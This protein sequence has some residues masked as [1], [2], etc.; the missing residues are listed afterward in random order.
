MSRN[1]LAAVSV[2]SLAFLTWSV[3]GAAH[4]AP[5]STRVTCGQTLTADTRLANSLVGCPGNGLVIGADGITVDL[6]GHSVRGTNAPGSEGIADDGHPGVRIRNG[7]IANF[8]LNGVALRGA[9]RSSL[10]NLTIHTIGAGG[11]ENDF[12]AGVLVKDSANTSI[13]NST[14][15]NNVTAFQSDGVDVL[16]S[17]GTRVSGNRIVD[18]AWNGMF[19]LDS[20]R[21]RVTGNDLDR[22]GNEGIEVNLGSDHTRLA[23]N[24]ARDN[25]ASGLVVGAISGARIEGNVVT[26]NAE[27]GVFMF[28]LHGSRITANRAASNGAGIDLEGGQHGSTGNRVAGNEARGNVAGIVVADGANDNTVVG[29]VANANTG[30]PDDGGGIIV[31]AASGNTVRGNIADRNADVGIGV[32]EDQPGDADGNALKGNVADFNR[33]HGIVAVAGTIDGGGNVAHGNTPP[34]NCLGVSCS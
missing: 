30:G 18:N 12:S 24:R 31:A 16:S 7:T 14:V 2:V 22:N 11:V 27:S 4:G 19:V 20:P 28:D 26:G 21:T 1:L 25:V 23:D 13:T 3:P 5:P 33:N 10:T 8:F 9:P 17:A 15:M 34:P 32:F 6:A 29:N